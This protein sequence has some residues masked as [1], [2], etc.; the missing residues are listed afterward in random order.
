MATTVEQTRSADRYQATW[1]GVT[2]SP[3]TAVGVIWLSAAAISVFSPDMVTGSEQDHLPIA[4]LTVWLWAAL[5]TA[6]TLMGTRG[7]DG[8]STALVI[9]VSVIWIAVAIASIAAPMMVTGTDPT[10]IPI[11][12]LVAPVVGAVTT[13]FVVLHQAVSSKL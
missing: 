5:S 7:P 6:Y 4:V 13:G 1:R 12:V 3:M 8:S 11:A 10:Q 2:R 9:G